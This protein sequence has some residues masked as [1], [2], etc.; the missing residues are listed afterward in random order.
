MTTPIT[1]QQLLCEVG[2][3]IHTQMP[4]TYL[5]AAEISTACAHSNGN[6]YLELIEKKPSQ[7]G[8]V[9]KAK[10]IVRRN[11][12]PLVA[13]SFEQATGRPLASGM[14]VLMEVKVVFHPVY[15]LQ[16]DVLDIDPTFTLG[17]DERRRREIIALL[18]ADGVV[19]LNKEL[20]LPRPIRRVAVISA[21]S[22]A[23]YG[24]FCKQLQQSGFPFHTKLFVATMQGEKVE[25]EVIAAL[26]AIADEMESWD[27][28]VVIRGGGAVSDLA[29]FNA[30]DLAT[31]IAQFPLPVFSGIGH[32]RDDTIV[33]L[34]AHTRFK[35][36]T[37][38]AAF[39]I[40]QYREETHLVRQL[41]ERMGHAVKQRL[42]AETSRLRLMG[43]QLQ[44]AAADVQNRSR[45]RLS[46]LYSRLDI[47][48]A[49][50]VRRHREQSAVLSTSLKNVLHTR[51]V[52]EQNR[53]AFIQKTAQMAD[54]ARVLALGFSYTT[55]GGKTIRSVTEATAGA[56]LITHLA[57]GNIYSRVVDENGTKD[58]EYKADLNS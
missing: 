32:E 21:A 35:T 25:R 57:D 26:N 23:G 48:A 51:L 37:A 14:E 28:V 1:L 22:A 41:A 11:I 5:V 55:S 31:N 46:V 6:C 18:E 19:G 40:E 43:V 33:D 44:K 52:A 4:D 12:Y 13:L 50:I 17:A 36:P 29:G 47:G 27:V 42:S 45:S 30:Y 39:L 8:F 56:L 58:K 20:P 16:L 9:A 3:T 49:G 7:T 15:G 54:P 38:V 34:V 10:A 53:L 2:E 24:D